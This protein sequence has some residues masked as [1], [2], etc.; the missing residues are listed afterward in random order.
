MLNTRDIDDIIAEA[1]AEYL[2]GSELMDAKSTLASLKRKHI[3]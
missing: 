2:S 1:E 3:G